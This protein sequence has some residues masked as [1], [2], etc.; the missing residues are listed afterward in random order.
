MHEDGIS[1][2]MECHQTLTERQNLQEFC[3]QIAVTP[4]VADNHLSGLTR[5]SGI[6]EEKSWG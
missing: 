6:L 2:Q 4:D 1:G 5:L 3:P